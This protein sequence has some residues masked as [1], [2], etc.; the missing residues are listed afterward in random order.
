MTRWAGC[1]VGAV[2][3]VL[4]AGAGGAPAPKPSREEVRRELDALWQDLRS[5]D[6]LTAGLALLRL[7]ARP[8]EAVDY[9]RGR[10]RPLG[11]SAARAAELIAALGGEDEATA[12]RAFDELDYQDPRLALGDEGLRAALLDPRAGRRVGAVLCDRPMDA[13]QVG[14]WHW[15]SPDNKVY[16][17]NYGE[18]V[19]DLDVSI[20][21]ADIGAR[22]RKLA[23]VRAERA[24]AALE[25]M[26][27]QGAVEVLEALAA[28]HPDAGPTKAAKRALER[29]RG[30]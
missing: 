19:R 23:W 3:A 7:A 5:P 28:G 26:R 17:F 16:R 24:V 8:T 21:V 18:A 13:F 15:N 11:L 30:R 25:Y 1:V 2:I 9:L 14:R 22:G 10:L 12:R 29:V 6:E 4:P 20:G 27:T